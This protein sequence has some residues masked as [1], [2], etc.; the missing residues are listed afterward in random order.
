MKELKSIKD[1]DLQ[2]LLD[3]ISEMIVSLKQHTAFTVRDAFSDLD[4]DTLDKDM[5]NRIEV[6]FNSVTS[7]DFKDTIKMIYKIDKT[8]VYIKL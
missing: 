4:W 7:K 5:Q 8:H 6:A 1:L 2:E 3:N